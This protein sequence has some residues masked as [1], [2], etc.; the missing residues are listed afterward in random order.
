MGYK[1]K[2][3]IWDIETT[4]MELSVRTYGLKSYT[5]YHHYKTI[6]R[7]WS[8]LGA[9][10]KFLD[11]PVIRCISVNPNDVFNDTH[12]VDILRTVLEQADILIGHNSDKFD[13]KKFNARALYHSMPPIPKKQSIDTLKQA[14]KIAAF[15]ANNL[16]YLNKYLG[17]TQKEHAP[18][19]QAVMDGDADELRKMREYNKNDVIATE[20]L[21]KRLRPYMGNHPN[22]NVYM[23]VKDTANDAV[24][25]C[26]KCGHNHVVRNGYT[27]GQARKRTRYVCY[28]CYGY[29][30]I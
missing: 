25:L 20:A 22:L 14:R 10:W 29:F 21:Y 3:L 13:L 2:I 30:T 28:G 18:D 26:P 15:S 19:W 8:I 6:K 4:D 17:I 23:D 27:H 7:D 11:D 12:V 9:A 5:N 24:I 16:G 1:P